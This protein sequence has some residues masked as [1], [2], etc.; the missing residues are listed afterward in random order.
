MDKNLKKLLEEHYRID[1]YQ[2]HNKELII[3]IANDT[4]TF[5]KPL[6]EVLSSIELSRIKMIIVER[7]GGELEVLKID[8][9]IVQIVAFLYLR[10]KLNAE[11][12][13]ALPAQ[14]KQKLLARA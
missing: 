12:T 1:I 3:K 14:I 4:E 8:E 13:P 5:H 11:T 10:R 7:E 2:N 6:Y 9:K